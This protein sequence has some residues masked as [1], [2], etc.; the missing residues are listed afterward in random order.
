MVLTTFKISTC[1]QITKKSYAKHRFIDGFGI[2]GNR[3]PALLYFALP[4][5]AAPHLISRHAREARFA[6]ICADPAFVIAFRT[7]YFDSI[8]GD[9]ALAIALLTEHLDAIYGDP[10][11]AADLGES[12]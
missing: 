1:K 5:Y 6:C 4:C 3:N 7:H 8:S 12:Q 2:L 10:C 11:L 9:P